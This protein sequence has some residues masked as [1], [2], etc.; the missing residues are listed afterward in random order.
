MEVP[1]NIDA[2]NI[3]IMSATTS[4]KFQLIK[5]KSGYPV[6]LIQ[7]FRQRP[8]ILQY[9]TQRAFRFNAG[10]VSP[11]RSNSLGGRD[12]IPWPESDK[13]PSTAAQ[14]DTEPHALL[15]EYCWPD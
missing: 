7:A 8:I 14:G 12:L 13:R 10:Q 1:E 2:R 3:I 9:A 6:D 4:L 5:S 11:P 15:R